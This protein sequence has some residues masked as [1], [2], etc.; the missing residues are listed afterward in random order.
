MSGHSALDQ[1]P[2]V[3]IPLG[4]VVPWRKKHYFDSDAEPMTFTRRA[5]HFWGDPVLFPL[6]RAFLS[7]CTAGQDNEYRYVFAL[8]GSELAGNAIRHS[9]SGEPGGCY[10]LRVDRSAEGLTLTCRDSG[11]PDSARRRGSNREYLAT[12]PSGLEP[13][14]DTGRG[15]HLVDAFA[16][17]WGDN[18]FADHRHVWFYLDFGLTGS[19][20]NT[21]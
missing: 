14:A 9:R 20:W 6:V 16:T 5:F 11:S 4:L 19:E 17:S 7:G 10:T 1:L 13:D 3:T 8:L 21:A 12:D 18:G 2:S 15:L